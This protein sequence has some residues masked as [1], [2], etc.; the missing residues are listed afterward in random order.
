MAGGIQR[1]PRF[2]LHELEHA[3]GTNNRTHLARTLATTPSTIHRWAHDG[4]PLHSADHA[5]TKLNLH[6]ANI[7]PHFL[8]LDGAGQ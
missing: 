5:A 1:Q 8:D 6:P 4:I 2:D 3:A 7:W